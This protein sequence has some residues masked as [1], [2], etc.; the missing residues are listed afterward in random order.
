MKTKATT[1]LFAAIFIATTAFAQDY[2]VTTK[3]D[4]LQGKIKMMNFGPEKK[5]TVISPDKKK[6]TLSIIQLKAFSLENETYHPMKGPSGYVFMK[7]IK[8][9]YLSLYT[10]QMP[11]Q[12]T[13]DGAFLVKKDGT[14]MEVPNL[15]FKKAIRK[16]VDDCP[17]TASRVD[18]GT[19]SRKNIDLIVDDYN[20][21]IDQNSRKAIPTAP[22]TVTEPVKAPAPEAWSVLEQK[23]KALEFDGKSDALEMITEIQNKL[24][25]SEKIPNFMIEGLKSSLRDKGLDAELEAAIQTIK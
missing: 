15:N 2:A 20:S 14:S 21:C 5:I 13:F 16:F 11:N 17:E 12:F 23:V 9:G 10:F 25:R 19:Y 24:S 3:G 6:T 8:E 1:G 4:T 18:D 7:L 22:P